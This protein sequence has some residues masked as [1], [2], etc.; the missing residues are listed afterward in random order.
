M[1]DVELFCCYSLNLKKFL[2]NNGVN[3]RI[4]AENP[5]NHKTFWVYVVTDNMRK[6]LKEWGNHKL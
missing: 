6:L 3:F 2:K 1:D 4:E 5:N